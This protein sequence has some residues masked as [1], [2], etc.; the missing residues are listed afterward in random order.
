MKIAEFV[1]R[2]LDAADAMERGGDAGFAMGL[3][4]L[5][6]DFED[7]VAEDEGLCERVVKRLESVSGVGGGAEMRSPR[8]EREGGSEMVP[9]DLVDD[10]L[11]DAVVCERWG[12]DM[13]AALLRRCAGELFEALVQESKGYAG[14]IPFDIPQIPFGW[15]GGGGG[16]GVA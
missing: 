9:G 10:W 16:Q 4:A 1:E 13:T 15:N 14:M 7:V 11:G 12:H 8:R 5:M 2:V 6:A 3:R